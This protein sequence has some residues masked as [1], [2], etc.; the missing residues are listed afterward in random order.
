MARSE[1]AARRY[2]EAAFEIAREHEAF[3][4][5]SASLHALAG[6]LEERDVA[7]VLE[8]TRVPEAEKERLLAAAAG[9]GVVPLAWNLGRLL[10]R[11][12]RVDLLPDIADLF[13]ELVN[14]ARGIV[15]ARVTTAVALDDQE[16][17]RVEQRL[18]TITGKRVVVQEQVDPAILGGMVARIGDRL[19]DGS[20][21]SRLLA[22]RKSLEGAE[23]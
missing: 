9:D 5:W 2:A 6:A 21:R 10:I 15:R 18:S 14:E 11:K 17:Q 13:D 3:D 20:T 1:T 23:R 4:E 8:S 12:Q 7:R 19:I 16:R 22:L